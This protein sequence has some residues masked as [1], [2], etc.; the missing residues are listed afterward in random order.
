M[1]EVAA[2]AD[3]WEKYDPEVLAEQAA[4]AGVAEKLFA[5]LSEVLSAGA[6]VLEEIPAEARERSQLMR[7]LETDAAGLIRFDP[8]IV[9]GFDY[10]TSTV[11]EVFDLHPDNRRSLFGGGRYDNL[12]GLYS[13]QRIPGFGFGMGDVTLFDFLENPWSAAR[14]GR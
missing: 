9:R 3:R 10:Y 12:V 1:R 13:N 4:G 11:F 6:A 7:V 8:M 14:A 5:R 2:L